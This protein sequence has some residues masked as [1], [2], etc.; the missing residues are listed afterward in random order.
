MISRRSHTLATHEWKSY[1]RVGV[2]RLE[3]WRNCENVATMRGSWEFYRKFGVKSLRV[4]GCGVGTD[5]A[6]PRVQHIVVDKRPVSLLRGRMTVAQFLRFYREVGLSRKK[7]F[8]L[9]GMRPNTDF[10]DVKNKKTKLLTFDM[11]RRIEILMAE[12]WRWKYLPRKRGF[13][14][15]KQQKRRSKKR[16]GSRLERALEDFESR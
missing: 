7:F 10:S 2:Q 8:G 11:S 6:P 1:R 4:Y 16:S 14:R 5:I 9:I 15:K 13:W 3:L 12:S